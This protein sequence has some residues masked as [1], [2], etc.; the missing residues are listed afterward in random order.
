[1]RQ[2]G[3]VSQGELDTFLA[4]CF[5]KCKVL[6]IILG[7]AQKVMSNYVNHFA[8]TPVDARFAAYGWQPGVEL[9]AE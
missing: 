3:H 2:R 6:E 7:L 8:D 1:M 5:T 9:A 4:S